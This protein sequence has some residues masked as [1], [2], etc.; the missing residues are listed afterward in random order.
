MTETECSVCV[1]KFNKTNHAHVT[2]PYCNFDACRSCSQTFILDKTVATCMNN[3]CNKEWTRKFLATAFTQKFVTGAWKLN[4]Q[5]VLFEREKA[6]LPATQLLVEQQIAKEKIR[7]RINDLDNQMDALRRQRD[8]LAHELQ[9]GSPPVERRQFVRACPEPECRGFLSTAWKCGLCEKWTCPDCHIVK[10]ERDADHTCHADDLAT[11]KLLDSDTKSC[12]KCAT[13][14]FKIEGCDQMWCTQ[15]HTAFS[16]KTGQIESRIH[17]PHFYEWQRRQ[18]A[19]PRVVGDIVC[20][21]ELD[22]HLSGRIRTLMQARKSRNVDQETLFLRSIDSLVQ[23]TIHLQRVQMPEYRLDPV[24]NNVRIRIDYLR[25][26]ITEPD[27][28]VK[29]QRCNKQ[30]E[31]KREIG[32]VLQLFVQTVTD[33]TYRLHERVTHVTPYALG[34]LNLYLEEIEGIRTYANE[35]LADIAHTYN[36]KAKAIVLNRNQG[37]TNVLVNT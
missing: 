14:I 27:F 16:W 3:A 26:K 4:R 5:K 13:G 2:C 10:G 15:C 32:E 12:P 22:H 7:A 23:A 25:Q 24:E 28:L 18:G 31:K 19:V 8:L 11:A 30:Y 9:T 35:C 33:I 20:G 37:V 29:I 34:E 6:M 1:E 21:R 36:V 17:N